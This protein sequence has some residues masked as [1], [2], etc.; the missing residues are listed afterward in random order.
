[1]SSATWCGPLVD[2]SRGRQSL[3]HQQVA[4]TALPGQRCSWS[5]LSCRLP[6]RS[7]DRAPGASWCHNPAASRTLYT[8]GNSHACVAHLTH[9]LSSQLS[10]LHKQPQH[11]LHRR[12][13]Q[14]KETPLIRCAHNGHLQAV[15]MLVARGAD[16]NALDLVR[17]HTSDQIGKINAGKLL[18][19]A[20]R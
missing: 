20:H 11:K 5:T 15:K 19:L 13:L 17:C 8:G 7:Q 4:W 14:M 9:C 1:M 16:V 12:G 18:H 2:P 10:A 6:G 3:L